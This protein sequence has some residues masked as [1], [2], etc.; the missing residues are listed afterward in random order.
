MMKRGETGPS[1]ILKKELPNNFRYMFFFLT[2]SNY[3]MRNFRQ[4]DSRILLKI[5]IVLPSL[6]LG[7]DTVDGRNPA[8]PGMYETL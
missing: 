6:A 8:T 7:L 2:F 1:D 3:V 4:I 5:C